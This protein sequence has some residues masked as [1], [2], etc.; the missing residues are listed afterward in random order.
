MLRVPPA[1]IIITIIIAIREPI[2]A[3]KWIIIP[4]GIIYWMPTPSPTVIIINYI[5]PW[6]W[7]IKTII[8]NFPPRNI[9]RDIARFS[10]NVIILIILLIALRISAL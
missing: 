1:L 6:M 2:R 9:N 10:C 8:V 5:H 3:I 4:V 7:L